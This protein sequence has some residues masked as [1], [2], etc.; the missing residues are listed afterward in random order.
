MPLVMRCCCEWA[1]PACVCSVR[2]LLR[3]SCVMPFWLSTKLRLPLPLAGA[4]ACCKLRWIVATCRVL[5]ALDGQ[6][7]ERML[8]ETAGSKRR[9]ALLLHLALACRTSLCTLSRVLRPSHPI[10]ATTRGLTQVES[11]RAIVRCKPRTHR[12]QADGATRALTPQA[13]RD[14]TETRRLDITHLLHAASHST[15]RTRTITF[16]S[17]FDTWQREG[18][19][20][21]NNNFHSVAPPCPPASN[22]SCFSD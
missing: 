22:L 9:G 17:L 18:Y 12:I 20:G 2:G 1:V 15:M 10:Y 7:A 14:S 6:M 4:D 3:A 21:T 8:C 11:S 16:T 13:R 5:R 19:L